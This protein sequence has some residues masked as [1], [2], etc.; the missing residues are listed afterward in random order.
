MTFFTV[1]PLETARAERPLSNYTYLRNST[2][3]VSVFYGA[4][5]LR[6]P[7]RHVLVDTGCDAEHYAAGPLS[8]VEDVESLEQNLGRHGLTIQDID[9]V[10]LTHL[11]F[12]HAAFLHL[13]R[14]CPK[15]VQEKEWQSARHP[16]PYFSRYYVP[17]F[18]QDS[19]FQ[20]IDGDRVLYPGLEV[21]L[22]SGHSA[23]SQAVVVE[24][25]EGRTA[26]SGFCCLAQNF[27]KNG[28]AVPGIHEDFQQ[29]YDSMIKLMKRADMIYANHSREPVRL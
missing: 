22:V 23:G 12:D 16:H 13:F 8:P 24:T 10:I 20:L 15:F 14:H 3:L 27:D 4:F 1:H 6:S 18:S 25:S 7:G 29:A 5:L 26:I 28:F 2:E 9:A 17:R 21:L 19:E 11:H